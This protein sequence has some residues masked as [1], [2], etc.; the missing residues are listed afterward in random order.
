MSAFLPQGGLV[1]TPRSREGG[2]SL[3]EILVAVAIVGM[4]SVLLY[5]AFKDTFDTQTEVSRSQERWHVLRIGMS[6]MVRDL[7]MAYVSM[8]ENMFEKDR[9]TY[10]ICKKG[11]DGDEL[12]F[13]AFAHRRT[14]ADAK[15]SDQSVI[16]YYLAPDPD[17]PRKTNL[18]RRETRRIA[19]KPFEDIPGESYIL[20]EDVKGIFYE[21]YDPVKDEWTEEWDTTAVDGQPNRLPP[22]IRISLTVEDE[23]GRD[24]TLVTAARII[25]TDAVNLTPPARGGRFGPTMGGRGRRGGSRSNPFGMPGGG[26]RMPGGLPGG[27]NK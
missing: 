20:I 25:L 15:E 6:R 10:F 2:F 8:N 11:F 1:V 21:F 5:G 3:I 4:M 13:S 16:R 26:M 19:Y 22:R 23:K 12:T 27:G 24:L 9:R 14:V 7:S 18:M 17:D